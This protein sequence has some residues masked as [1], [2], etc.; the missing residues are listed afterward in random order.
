MLG[1]LLGRKTLVQTQ[2]HDLAIGS[3]Q[4]IN[5]FL[6]QI[7]QFPFLSKSLRVARDSRL[8]FERVLA[9]MDLI[10]L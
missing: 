9:A 1:D 7:K 8:I 3:W 2:F 4:E 6:K 5:H 10:S